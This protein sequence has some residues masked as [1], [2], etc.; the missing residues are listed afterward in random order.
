[1]SGVADVR[2]CAGVTDLAYRAA[3]AGAAIIKEAV[4]TTGRCSLV[5]SGGDTPRD[6][7]RRWASRFA[8]EIPWAGVHIFW[9]DERFVPAED[10][11][12]NYKMAKEALLDQLPIPSANVHAML[13]SFNT[14]EPAASAYDAM[15]RQHF[16]GDR[17]RFDLLLLGLGPEGHTASLFP[18]SPALDETARWVLPVTVPADPQSRL[19]LTLPALNGATHT[20]VLVT[21]SEKAAAL[22]HVLSQNADVRTYP[23]AGIRT[24]DGNSPVWWIDREA[25][26][27]YRPRS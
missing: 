18:R 19:T 15:L 22:E 12:S 21:G 7:Y 9:G 26:A 13:T 20:Y 6:L 10:R 8:D 2:V 17:P 23:A 25:A 1:M 16:D 3:E 4:Q 11:R 24:A 14:P 5:L 27:L